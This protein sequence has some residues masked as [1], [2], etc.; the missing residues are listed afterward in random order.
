MEQR[1]FMV[2]NIY[3]KQ[4]V[5]EK[6]EKPANTKKEMLRNNGKLKKLTT[7]RNLWYK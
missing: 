2:V 5:N 7:N 4:P 1:P 6:K 3:A